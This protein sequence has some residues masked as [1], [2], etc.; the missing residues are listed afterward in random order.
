[1]KR[2][3]TI[4]VYR[5]RGLEPPLP[6]RALGLAVLTIGAVAAISFTIGLLR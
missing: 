2:E 6:R 1:V 4:G 3:I 5:T